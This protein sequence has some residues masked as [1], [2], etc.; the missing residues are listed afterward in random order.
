[1][2]ITYAEHSNAEAIYNLI[3]E[4]ENCELDKSAFI[5]IFDKNLGNK[6]IQYLVS[7]QGNDIVGFISIYMHYLLHHASK[8][9][10]IQELIITE[11]YKSQGIGSM[12]FAKAK[13]TAKENGCSQ[14]EVC[15]NLRRNKSHLFYEKQGMEKTSYKFIIEL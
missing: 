12:L 1:M 13:E 3:C 15:C 10:E 9:A 11:R 7:K 6:D 4:L 5:E 2:E 14:M 8:I